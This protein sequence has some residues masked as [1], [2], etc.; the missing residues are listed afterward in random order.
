MD[1]DFTEKMRQSLATMKQEI[2]D[3]LVATNADFRA[4]VEVNT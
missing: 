1:K 2:L 3:K 4:I